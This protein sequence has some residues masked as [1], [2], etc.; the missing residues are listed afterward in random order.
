[1][2]K[3]ILIFS[4]LTGLALCS[5]EQSVS[6]RGRLLCG[7]KPASD[8]RIRLF[9]EDTGPDPDDLLDQS[10][11]DRDGRFQVSGS[12]S[13]LMD[14]DPLFRVYHHCDDGVVPGAR[15]V[16]FGIPKSYVS[17]GTVPSMVF[18]IGT[19]N[20]ETIFPDEGREIFE[21][22]RRRR[23]IR[24][25][26]D[27]VDPY[28]GVI[29]PGRHV[30]TSSSSSSEETPENPQVVTKVTADTAVKSGLH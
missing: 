16:T 17:D 6:A 4:L 29:F 26:D 10:Y 5:R 13:E 25:E 15:K 12:T 9:D 21:V 28:T 30:K 27:F 18:D 3:N 11:S 2:S 20:L 8:V 22:K 7:D 19:L 24:K 1:M 23:A 14:I